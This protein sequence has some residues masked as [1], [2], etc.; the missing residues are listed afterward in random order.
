MPAVLDKA[1]AAEKHASQKVDEQ[2]AQATSRIR[3]HDAAFGSLVL[4]AM[5]LVYA[6]GMILLDKYAVLPDWARQLGLVSFFGAAAATGWYTIGRSFTRRVNPL[7]AAV[8]VEKTIDDAKNSVVGY[9]EAQENGQVHPAVK[10]AM[11]ARAAKTVTHADLNEAVEHRSLLYAGGVAAVFL[12]AL[13]ALFFVFRPAQFK[14]LAARTFAPFTSNEIASRTQLELVEPAGGDVTITTGQSITVKVNVIG[15]VPASGK[16]DSLRVRI[17]HT[18]TATEFEEVPLEK[19]EHSRE[20]LVRVPDHL[21]R[22]GFWYKVAGGDTETAEHRVTVR[23]LP[24]FTDFTVSYEFPAYTR[25][26][27]ETSTDAHLRAIRGTKVAIVGKTNRTVKDGR[28]A[29]DPVAREP[30]LGKLVADKPDSIQ[31]AFVPSASGHYRMTFTSSEGERSPEPPPFKITVDEDLAPHVDILK[32]EEQEI[33]LPANGQL[34]VDGIATDDWGLE[35]MTLKLK[36]VEPA[37]RELASF[38]FQGGKSFRRTEADGSVSWPTTLDYKGSVDFTKLTDAGGQPVKLEEGMVI[39]YWLEATDNRTKP[40]ATGPEADPNIGKSDV[41]KVRLTP[42]VVNMEDRKQLDAKKE[43]RKNEEQANNAAQ[44]K[45]LDTEKRDPQQPNNPMPPMPMNEPMPPMN[46]DPATPPMK[47]ADPA[48]PKEPMKNMGDPAMPMMPPMNNM[49][50]PG[51]MPETAPM[52]ASPDDRNTQKQADEIQKKIEEQ[53]G[54]GGAK[55]GPSPM[56]DQKNP[57][58]PKPMPMSGDMPPPDSNPKEPPKDSMNRMGGGAADSKPM[59]EP[60]KNEEPGSAKPE[61]S[62]MNMNMGGGSQSAENKTPPKNMDPMMGGAGSEKPESKDGNPMATGGAKPE[63][64][65]NDDAGQSKPMPGSDPGMEKPEPKSGDPMEPPMGGDAKP[66]SSPQPSGAKPG[67]KDM[68]DPMSGGA[69]DAKPMP[70]DMNQGGGETKPDMSKP[71]AGG[72]QLEKGVD[73]PSPEQKPASGGGQKPTPEQQ[74]EFEQ[75]LKDLASGDPAKQQAARDKLDK[76]VGEKNRKDIEQGMKDFEKNVKDLNSKDDKTRADA[77]KNL[78]TQVGEKNRKEIEDIQKGLNSDDPKEK[79]AAQEKLKDLQQKAGAGKADMQPKEKEGKQPDPKDVEQAMKD[80][81]SPDP[82]KRDAAKK[83]LDEQFG[84]GAGEKAEQLQNDLKSDEMA[85]RD[86]AKRELDEM[87]KKAGELAK[88]NPP[89][90][91]PGTGGGKKADP[92][93]VE[94]ALDDVAGDDPMKKAEGKKKLDDMLGQGAGDKAEK[95][96]E[97]MKSDDLAK[98]A[99]ARKERDDLLNQAEKMAKGDNPI[100]KG[101]Q[102]SKEELDRLAKNLQNLESKD[103]AKRKQAEQELDKQ[104]GEQ[105]RKDLQYAMKDPKRAEELKKKLEE[106]RHGGGDPSVPVNDAMKEDARNRAKSAQLQLEQFEK[107]KDNKDL[108][109][110]LNMTPEEYQAFV[111][112]FRKQAESLKKEVDELE[113]ADPKKPVPITENVSGGGKIESKGGTSGAGT[114]AGPTIAAPGYADA[115]RE[116]NK[117]ASKAPPKR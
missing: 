53:K 106:L 24:L 15:Q 110:E 23:T 61:P 30:L 63:P 117:G 43:Q 59:G 109:K 58:E 95:A 96:A 52:P 114:A 98:Q 84:K 99:E 107:N 6:T 116:F 51:G 47:N 104:I 69:S 60:K 8:Q 29:F 87:A 108:L 103:E 97:K 91:E 111:D 34:A 41:K 67:P 77:Q 115:L 7:Y 57:A 71:N 10:A 65:K 20:W 28:L 39:E 79:A 3:F 31:F 113:K 66:Q 17:R 46:M 82:A 26:K 48:M 73:K 40:G 102:P 4:L 88:N 49:G 55:A 92:K 100:P 80:L 22:N 35:G 1:P 21:V 90:K 42:P 25:L 18:P 2:I 64:K 27:P 83:K 56:E 93:E 54:A 37:A 9:V 72:M 76:Q 16:P 13:V 74:K 62:P 11:G 75:N 12:L 50:N 5:T 70:K 32:P 19:G 101:K 78:D 45:R 36:L 85:K 81:Q 68:T 105:A 112:R 94:K 14:S 86:A 44:Q 89:K 33:Q 38:K